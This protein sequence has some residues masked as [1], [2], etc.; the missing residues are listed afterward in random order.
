MDKREEG[1]N[2]SELGNWNV[3]NEYSKKKIMKPLDLCD[4]YENIAKF[5]YDSIGEQLMQFGVPTD[6]LRLMGFNRLVDELLKLI[7]NAKFAMKVKGTLG[8]IEKLEEYLEKIKMTIPTLSMKIN[9]RGKIQI[10]K[11]HEEKFNKVLAL[12]L[13]IKST[14]NDPLNKNHLIFTDKPKFDPQ[15]HKQ[16]LI[17]SAT[18]K[19]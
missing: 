17:E 7:S 9:K 14:I 8:E 3:A 11:I 5:G 18:T 6:D 15:K 12:V 4:L 13:K 16:Q 19:G 1:Y 10:T 2:V